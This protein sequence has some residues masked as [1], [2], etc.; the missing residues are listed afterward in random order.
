[1]SRARQSPGEEMDKMYLK[2]GTWMKSIGINSRPSFLALLHFGPRWHLSNYF[3][4]VLNLSPDRLERP[5]GIY[6]PSAAQC[7][8]NIWAWYFHLITN[9]LTEPKAKGKARCATQGEF[10]VR[11]GDVQKS[12]LRLGP[13][14][15][16]A[17]QRQ[18]HPHAKSKQLSGF[19]LQLWHGG[20]FGGFISIRAH[21][22]PEWQSSIL[23]GALQRRGCRHIDNKQ[24]GWGGDSQWW[25]M[26]ILWV[27]GDFLGGVLPFLSHSLVHGNASQK[28][29][30]G[31]T[32][33]N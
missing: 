13:S 15:G 24:E 30:P 5:A 31:W 2:R 10:W 17:E 22:H 18:Q 26:N 33:R 20:S 14:P 8:R 3:S 4:A 11:G 25:Q 7:H 6:C 1:M 16:D 19:S 32:A 23:P 12:I 28:L 21:L 9:R 29:P 27:L